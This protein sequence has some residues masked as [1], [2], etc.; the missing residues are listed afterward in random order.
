MTIQPSASGGPDRLDVECENQ[1]KERK[2][3]GERERTLLMIR[4]R[5]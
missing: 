4:A 5:R 3:A 2:R 1:Q